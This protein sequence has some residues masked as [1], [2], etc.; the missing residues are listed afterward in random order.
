MGLSLLTKGLEE[1]GASRR[2]DR[3]G[4]PDRQKGLASG[5]RKMVPSSYSKCA[6]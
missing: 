5:G 4:N 1:P 3:G 2:Q 6:H